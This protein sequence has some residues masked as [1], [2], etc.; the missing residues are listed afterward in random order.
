MIPRLGIN[1]DHVATVRQA[2]GEFYPSVR[3]AADMVIRNGA[4]QITIHVREDRRHVQDFDAADVRAVT[5]EHGKL[6]NL[7]M[8]TAENVFEI[9][10]NTQPDWICLVPEKREEQTTEGGI[11]L[12]DEKTF[13]HLKSYCA[14]LRTKVP[15]VKISLFLEA[16]IEILQKAQELNVEAVEIHTGDFCKQYLNKTDFQGHLNKFK[17]AHN[18]LKQHNIHCHAGHGITQEMLPLLLELQV[19]EEYNIGHWVVAEAL[20]QGLGPVVAHMKETLAKYP[21]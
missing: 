20:F 3:R 5:K 15:D 1:I 14:R 13:G 10:C 16:N 21:L 18:F 19:F 11:N 8:A 9:A 2:R 7:E 12:L 6:F 4:D 17:D